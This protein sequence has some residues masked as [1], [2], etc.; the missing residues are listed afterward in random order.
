[1]SRL[2]ASLSTIAYFLLTAGPSAVTTEPVMSPQVIG[3]QSEFIT[4]PDAGEPPSVPGKEVAR[5][6]VADGSF[7]FVQMRGGE[8]GIVAEGRRAVEILKGITATYQTTPLMVFVGAG[9]N[10]QNAPDAL[11]RDH[12]L[13]EAASGPV[14]PL[15]PFTSIQFTAASVQGNSDIGVVGGAACVQGPVETYDYF[16]SWW[17]GLFFI[18]GIGALADIGAHGQEGHGIWD[19]GPANLTLGS[20]SAG[21]AL[22]CFPQ[23]ESHTSGARVTVQEYWGNGLWLDLWSTPSVFSGAAY[24]YW[25]QGLLVHKVRVLIRDSRPANQQ[26]PPIGP[27]YWAGAY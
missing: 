15:P 18:P 2:G 20:T 22:V 24:G 12:R 7:V 1:M 27:F 16:S 6:P 8:V 3:V 5:L 19:E 23:D 25:F 9:G 4:A 26:N 10:R 13:R 11:L 14:V 21:A 17:G